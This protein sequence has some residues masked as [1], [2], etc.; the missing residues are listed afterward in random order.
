MVNREVSGP[1]TAAIKMAMHASIVLTLALALLGLAVGGFVGW[2]RSNVQVA[3]A[4]I[5]INPLDGNPFSTTGSGDDLINM[6]TESELMRS[7]AVADLVRED[8]GTAES[9]AAV[10]GGLSVS[11]P[12]NSQIIEISYEGHTRDE[13]TARAQAFAEQYLV[14]RRERATTLAASQG[15]RVEAQVRARTKE[16]TTLSRKLAV[17]EPGS[18]NATVLQAQLDAATTQINQLRARAS[19]I[20]AMPINPGQVVTPATI[21]P[22][23]PLGAKVAFPLAGLIGGLLTALALTLIRARL[24]NRI[25]HAD[26]ISVMGHKLLGEVSASES[27]SIASAMITAPH[28]ARP[29]DAYRNLRVKILTA[30][31]RRPLT[32]LVATT[33]AQQTRPVT[34]AALTLA[35]AASRL[36]TVL[37][38]AAGSM[39]RILDPQQSANSSLGDVLGRDG[40]PELALTELVP[41][42]KFIRN[43]DPLSVEDSFMTPQ[44]KRLLESLRIRS[45]LVIFS[46]G[47]IHDSRTLAIADSCDAVILEATAGASTY[48]DLLKSAEDLTAIAEKLL[49]VVL[50]TRPTQVVVREA[51]AAKK[52]R[53]KHLRRKSEQ[54]AG[55]T[56]TVDPPHARP[57][58]HATADD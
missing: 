6:V 33:S 16:Q 25:H 49:G 53:R 44:M 27:E 43:D 34:V 11:V 21:A 20:E 46:A 17:A 54:P 31:H 45:D 36:E 50:V 10:L 8:L 13:A 7:D 9:P 4:T 24:D 23:G 22:Q 57:D 15:E 14:F 58:V 29:T 55:R 41:H 12:P 37:V 1:R 3:E 40:N 2:N 18:D 38:D 39:S 26:D 19:E 56:T 30:D 48:T 52:R 47:S 35:M 5:L 51:Q 32:I 28:L 42:A